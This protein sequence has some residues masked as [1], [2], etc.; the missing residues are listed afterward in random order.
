MSQKEVHN[1]IETRPDAFRIGVTI[2]GRRV[3]TT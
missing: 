3:L 2:F 1:V